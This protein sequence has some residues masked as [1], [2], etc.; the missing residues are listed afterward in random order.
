[1][2]SGIKLKAVTFGELD[3]IFDEKGKV[4]CSMRKVQWVKEG[5][6]PDEEKAKLELRKYT[7]G[8]EGEIPGKGLTFLTENGPHE[9]TNVLIDE[10]FGDTREILRKLKKRDDFREAVETLFENAPADDSDG[11]YFDMRSV[12]LDESDGEDVEE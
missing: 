5:Q 7:I 1:M 9:L 6:E 11:E 10:G 2:N 12:L 8:P 3:G 4:F